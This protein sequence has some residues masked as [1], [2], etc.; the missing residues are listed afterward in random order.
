MEAERDPARRIDGAD[1]RGHPV[2]PTN[3]V[4]GGW[5]RATIGV[6][7]AEVPAPQCRVPCQRGRALPREESLRFEYE[8]IHVPVAHRALDDA[9][10]GDH[11]EASG[12]CRAAKRPLGNEIRSAHV[13][14]KKRW[15]DPK[16][17]APSHFS[18]RHQVRERAIRDRCRSGLK[19]LPEE[20][21]PYEIATPLADA[22][23]IAFDLAGVEAPPPPHG[24]RRRPVVDADLEPVGHAMRAPA[25]T[26]SYTRK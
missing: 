12:R 22:S 2:E 24:T 21:Q 9:I 23:E 25:S 26:C 17:M 20:K 18:D 1:S 7:V 6:L 19:V 4:V 13:A 15:H 11:A 14:H 3:A 8:R 10:V 5:W 16:G